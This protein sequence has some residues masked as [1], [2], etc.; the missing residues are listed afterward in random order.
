M[1]ILRIIIYALAIGGSLI[2]FVNFN[3]LPKAFFWVG[4][5]LAFAGVSQITGF[6]LGLN[7]ISNIELYNLIIIPYTLL[8]YLIF[9]QLSQ[10]RRIRTWLT[11]VFVVALGLVVL[12][13]INDMTLSNEFSF[14]AILISSLAAVVGSLISLF[15]KI[16]NPMY[17]TPLKMGWLWLL[18]GFLF[19]YSSTFT[20]W[21][22]YK[23]TENVFERST[24]ILFN[25]IFVL[26][27]YVMLFVAIIIQL[28]FS[29]LKNN[30]T[31]R[32]SI[33]SASLIE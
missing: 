9:R 15:E 28:K 29:D 25:F 10:A 14:R 18:M 7:S 11:S 12:F 13:L 19:Y 30:P 4:V 31:P 5:Y 23:F 27:F 32:K 2:C 3:K 24:L 20:Y 17:N 6:L 8:C 1:D 26:T 22:A 21:A 16:K 33:K